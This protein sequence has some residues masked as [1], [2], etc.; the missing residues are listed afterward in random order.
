MEKEGDETP[1]E[2]SILYLH[3]NKYII[4]TVLSTAYTIKYAFTCEILF[5]IKQSV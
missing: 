3:L 5:C 1:N 4:H 2:M